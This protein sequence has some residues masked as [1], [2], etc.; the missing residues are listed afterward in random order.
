[1]LS[2]EELNLTSTE[3]SK[4]FIIKRAEHYKAVC[5][6]GMSYI[7]KHRDYKSAR[8]LLTELRSMLRLDAKGMMSSLVPKNAPKYLREYYSHIHGASVEVVGAV[9]NTNLGTS[10]AGIMSEINWCINQVKRAE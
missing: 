10:F 9:K 8:T 5:E 1:M 2:M 7:D 6:E 4:E 3:Y